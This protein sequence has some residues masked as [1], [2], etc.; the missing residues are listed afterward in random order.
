[1]EFKPTDVLIELTRRCNLHCLHCGSDCQN[2]LDPTELSTRDWENVLLQ[3][4]DLGIKKVVFSG[5]EPT[6][7]T[8]LGHLLIFAKRLDL[9]VGFISNG[10]ADFRNSLGED[11]VISQPFSVGLSLDGLKD[12]HN[13]IRGNSKSWE[14]LLANID[15]LQE[16]KI[17]ICAVTTLHKLNWREL[18][19]LAQWLAL[20]EIDSWQIQLAMPAG[21]MGK[22]TDLLLSEEEFQEVC[23]NI[24]DLRKKYPQLYIQAAD[25]FGWAGDDLIR[26]GTWPG[27]QAGISSCA[28]DASGYLLP[29]LSLQGVTTPDN[30]Q[31]KPVAE[32]WKKSSVFDFNRKFD[33][34][35]VTGNCVGCELLSSC[36]GGCNSQSHS[37]YGCYHNSPFCF[38]R[39]FNKETKNE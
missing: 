1:M 22:L 5:G 36:R 3:L 38:Y 18:P 2:Q 20:A 10:S 12:T 19:K 35:K 26:T 37:Y 25:C 14:R 16:K 21:R 8:D 4:Y 23:R 6:L 15:F 33:A 24:F 11:L 32:I 34:L 29:C 31:E 17:P 13:K 28:I 30:C 27:C 39:S 7:R 9:K